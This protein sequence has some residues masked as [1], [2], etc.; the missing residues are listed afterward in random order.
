MNSWAIHELHHA[1]GGCC[2]SVTS[3]EGMEKN[4]TSGWV[5]KVTYNYLCDVIY[6]GNKQGVVFN[7]VITASLSKWSILFPKIGIWTP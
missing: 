4:V 7:N 1:G 6:G 5:L 3:N 2:L